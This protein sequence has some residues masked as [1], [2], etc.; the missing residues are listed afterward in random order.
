METPSSDANP[1][2]QNSQ[3]HAD[4]G[5]CIASHGVIIYTKEAPSG[6]Q[7]LVLFIWRECHYARVTKHDAGV[8]LFSLG[9]EG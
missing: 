8:F 1:R 4:L 3:G 2:Q 9:V 7:L 5:N 6:S